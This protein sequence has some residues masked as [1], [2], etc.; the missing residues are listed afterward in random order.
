[1][2]PSHTSQKTVSCPVCGR[3]VALEPPVGPLS[4]TSCPRCDNALS[5]EGAQA[6]S[7]KLA[8]FPLLDERTM[9][10]F[11]RLERFLEESH[12]AQLDLDFEGVVFLSSAA[13]GKLIRLAKTA[14]SF[15]GRVVLR[16]VE[17][18]IREVLDVTHTRGLFQ[19]EA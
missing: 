19:I 12:P 8:K 16:H 1:M 3:N 10:I 4:A 15:E 5:L 18:M 6:P 2:P 11:E 9:A 13:L 7:I 17:P 14:Q